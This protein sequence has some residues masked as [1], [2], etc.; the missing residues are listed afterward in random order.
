MVFTSSVQRQNIF[1]KYVGTKLPVITNGY[2]KNVTCNK[3]AI[4]LQ[5]SL[6]EDAK[7]KRKRSTKNVGM[8]NIWFWFLTNMNW[9]QFLTNMNM[10]KPVGGQESLEKLKI[11]NDPLVPSQ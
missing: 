1:K 7:Y 9:F 3:V 5:F 11:K 2:I 6:H 4:L 10:T 8:Q